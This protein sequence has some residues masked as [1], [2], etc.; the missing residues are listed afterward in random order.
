MKLED[1]YTI[2]TSEEVVEKFTTIEAELNEAK[3]EFRKA[4]VAYENKVRELFNL[5]VS[6]TNV[7][8]KNV[9]NSHTLVAVAQLET[10]LRILKA[11]FNGLK[12]ELV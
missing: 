9:D 8:E 1:I 2:K 6:L 4:I 12:C 11:R 10:E 5:S 7:S 3:D